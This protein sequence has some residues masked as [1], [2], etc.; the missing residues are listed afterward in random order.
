M[1]DDDVSSN[2]LQLYQIIALTDAL[3]T[4]YSSISNDYLLL[5]RPMIFTLDDYEEYRSSRGFSVDD[6]AQYF[7][8]HHVYNE[9]EFFKAIEDISNDL[10]YYKEK[11]HELLPIMHKNQDGNSSERIIEHIGLCK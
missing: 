5:D 2:G 3:I 8:G 6:P 7:P 1:N 4:D 11:R 10:D 9:E